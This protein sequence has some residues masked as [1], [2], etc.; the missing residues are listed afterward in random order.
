[1]N[2]QYPKNYLLL[3]TFFELDL[4]LSHLTKKI[5]TNRFIEVGDDPRLIQDIENLLL[6]IENRAKSLEPFFDLT[7]TPMSMA[8]VYFGFIKRINDTLNYVR[9]VRRKEYG[10]RQHTSILLEMLQGCTQSIY[11][12]GDLVT[13]GTE[14]VH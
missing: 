1:M 11:A 3:K 4:Q 14:T 9:D 6:H 13:L 2:T 12:I 10:S 7:I 8:N 5:S